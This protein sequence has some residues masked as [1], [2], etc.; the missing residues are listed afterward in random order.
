MGTFFGL[1]PGSSG[2]VDEQRVPIAGVED[3]DHHIPASGTGF[4]DERPHLVGL[5]EVPKRL[6]HCLA[7]VPPRDVARAANSEHDSLSVTNLHADFPPVAMP[8]IQPAL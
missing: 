8:S 5:G 7:G 4:G 1:T 3:L 6:C 2:N